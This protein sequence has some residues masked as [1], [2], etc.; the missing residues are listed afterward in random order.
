MQIKD[1]T[2]NDKSAPVIF[3]THL[4][5]L[6]STHLERDWEDP[7]ALEDYAY[8]QHTQQCITRLALGLR[9]SSSLRAW[10][11]TG[12]YGSGKS[13]FALL[14]ANIFDKRVKSIPDILKSTIGDLNPSLFKN[15]QPRLIPIL[16]T[17]SR[18]PL[19]HAILK[20]IL[21]T[22]ENEKNNTTFCE[23][24]KC[25]LN[26]PLPLSDD[27]VLD[28]VKKSHNH[29]VKTK[30]A[31]GIALIID[32]AGKF[33]E[34]AA[35]RPDQQD[36][37]L[38]QSLAEIAS[39]S[40]KHPFYVISILHQGVSSY[41][42]RLSKAQQRE[43]E[44]VA[45]RYEEIIWHYPV[46]QTV[47]LIA[48]CLDTNLSAVP[49]SVLATNS[50]DMVQTLELGWYGI[51]INTE[52]LIEIAPKLYPIHPTVVP[53]LV[54]LFSNFGQNERSLYS[55]LLGT[56]NFGLQDF[57]IKTNGKS[58][59]KLHNLYD[60]ARATFGSRLANL[61][62]HWKAIDNAIS[63]YIDD[64][65]NAMQLLK[66]VGMINLINSDDLVASK[67][68]IQLAIGGVSKDLATLQK[69]HFLHFRGQAGGYC[70]W[71][72]TSVNLQECYTS[73]TKA[74]TT[75][76]KDF[77]SLIRNRLEARPIVARR[78]YIETG[79][80][81][82]FE[83][84]YVDIGD[85][86]KALTASFSS[87][88][89]IIVPLC[90]TQRDVQLAAN[91]AKTIDS[92]KYANVLIV[93]SA[94]LQDLSTFLEEVRR[95][96]WIERSIG[97]LRQD[98][99]AREEV[100]RQLYLANAEL[101][102]HLQE[103]IGLI[104]FTNDIS[105]NWYHNGKPVKTLFTGKDVMSLLTQI[106]DSIFTSSPRIHNELINRRELS[107]A[108]ASAR[109]RLCERL[110][111]YSDQPFLGMDPEKHPPEMS[112]YLSVLHEA[113]LHKQN[114][115]NGYWSVNLP[116][117]AY[118]AIHCKVL[119]S[120][121]RIHDILL[122]KPDKRV[123][124][125]TLFESLRSI[126]YGVKDGMIPLLI[127]VFAVIHEQEIAFYEDGSFIPRIT[128]SN[129]LRLIK[130]PETFEIQYY[131][132]S[133]IRNTLFHR[134]IRELGLQ[135][136]AGLKVDILD[137]VR[138]LAVFMAGLPD[139]VVNTSNLQPQTQRIR[140]ILRTTTDPV[141]LLFHDLPKACDLNP[142]PEKNAVDNEDI[143]QFAE[144][145]KTSIDELR[146]S[147][148]TLLEHLQKELLR[149]FNLNG[150]FE[151]NRDALAERA[152][153]LVGYVTEIRLK[154]FCLRL[155]DIILAKDLWL[156]SLANL[157]CSMPATKWR[158]KDVFKFEQEIHKLTHQF[159]RVEAT[160][161]SQSGKAKNG[162]SVR[163][164]L[165]RPNGEE[166]DQVIYLN[167]N[168][169][170]EVQKIENELKTI[171]SQ[172]GQLGMAAASSVLWQMMTADEK[173]TL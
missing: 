56:E 122:S 46:E 91:F 130:A 134:L 128:G 121:N 64:S 126:P 42:E 2:M 160:L 73:A 97:E 19:G 173:E 37:Y 10:R 124:V 127:A 50:K 87:D 142:I 133:T 111:E 166:R 21:R 158:D 3:K 61:S 110:F 145:L 106:C 85:L 138:P 12:D 57:V 94:P 137:V 129:F 165:T 172:H 84:K 168:Q 51:G 151:K 135:T 146:G 18:E 162:I 39:R 40:G 116:D 22:F 5:Y 113:G 47:S 163:V 65:E 120:M 9:Q 13:S 156:E 4:R 31:E 107:S 96:E 131:P 109:L 55:F 170:K 52:R 92:H 93:I 54:K 29:I 82:Y 74:L 34:F 79:N 98:K 80:L 25:Q 108:G 169:T 70:V 90:E 33:L 59:F 7:L 95:W 143:D 153:A 71:P 69:K 157:I 139:Y 112:M 81:R 159:L 6:R 99:F 26:E 67:E 45:G 125:P 17:G 154:S 161:Y 132:I 28:W 114:D 149:E 102:R 49:K 23:S 88:G 32:E 77:R 8:T 78:H 38:L 48:N 83:I 41:A 11:I 1:N 30:K 140:T 44:K 171:L 14:V 150:S 72:N 148:P 101:Q 66:T 35:S 63:S 103:T 105:L 16:I 119:P 89:V 27:V 43:W 62:Y 136:K 53:I 123:P 155:T 115:D 75:A 141:Q 20:S 58:L 144:R 152:K 68:I 60:Y 76:S 147:Y 104:S 86:E 167:A 100:S 118:D 36:I 117:E 24:L 164:A 15:S